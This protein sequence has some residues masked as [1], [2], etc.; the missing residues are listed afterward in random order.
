MARPA[1]EGVLVGVV[2]GDAHQLAVE[3]ADFE[4]ELSYVSSFLNQYFKIMQLLVFFFN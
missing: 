2:N 1:I 4:R 3:I